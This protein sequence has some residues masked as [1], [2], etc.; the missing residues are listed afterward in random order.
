MSTIKAALDSARGQVA[1][2]F[3]LQDGARSETGNRIKLG[4]RYVFEFTSNISGRL[5][6]VDVDANGKVTQIFPNKFVTAQSVGR[7]AA[8]EK[9][10]IP[11]PGYGFDWFRATEPLGKGTLV[12]IIMPQD[13]P[14]KRHVGSDERLSK[15]FEPERSPANY[16]MNLAHEI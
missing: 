13:F 14:I 12:S 2:R 8:N 15:G 7:V 11:G 10:R 3:A 1:A 16:L 6:I 5:V 4:E 9:I